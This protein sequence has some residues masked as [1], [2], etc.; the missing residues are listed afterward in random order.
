MPVLGKC[1]EPRITVC[2]LGITTEYLK[3]NKDLIFTVRI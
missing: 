3:N 1:K 2:F